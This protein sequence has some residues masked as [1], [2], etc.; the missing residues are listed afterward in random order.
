MSPTCCEAVIDFAG[1]VDCLRPLLTGGKAFILLPSTAKGSSIARIMPMPSPGTHV[2]TNKNDIDYF[3]TEFGVA[4]LRGKLARQRAGE[5][6]AI[7]HPAFRAE[8]TQQAR[9]LNLA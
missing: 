6:V 5:L 7:A 2:S 9:R 8:L 4:Q 3:V 1:L